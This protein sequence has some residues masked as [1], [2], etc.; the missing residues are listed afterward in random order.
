[1]CVCCIRCFATWYWWWI[2]SVMSLLFCHLYSFV[3]PP[4][5]ARVHRSALPEEKK[6]LIYFIFLTITQG[7]W[8]LLDLWLLFVHVVLLP[9]TVEG[10]QKLREILVV[11][12]TW[13][14]QPRWKPIASG[15]S[16][17]RRTESCSCAPFSVYCEVYHFTSFLFHFKVKL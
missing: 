1:M 8:I 7:W 4:G 6:I 13:W 3:P 10:D 11:L 14:R 5:F 15:Q 16:M 17:T 2:R 9:R 12:L